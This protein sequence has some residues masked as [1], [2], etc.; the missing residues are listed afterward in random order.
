MRRELRESA[1]AC[2]Q[3][4]NDE[5]ISIKESKQSKVILINSQQIPIQYVKPDN[6]PVLKEE[7]RK[8]CDFLVFYENEGAQEIYIEFKGGNI[9]KAVQQIL[10]TL[11]DLGER[12]ANRRCF[13]VSSGSGRR[14]N[15]K[16]RMLL[17]RLCFFKYVK[18]GHSINVS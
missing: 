10:D 4:K 17:E 11:N 12:A 3:V 13:V 18:N 8:R 15:R 14:L 6:C 5:K 1:S 7:G 16:K 2:I 9:E